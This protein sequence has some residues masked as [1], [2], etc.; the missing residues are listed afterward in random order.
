[1]VKVDEG[2]LRRKEK[3]QVDLWRRIYRDGWPHEPP[4]ACGGPKLK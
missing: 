4:V 2:V 1:M 3:N